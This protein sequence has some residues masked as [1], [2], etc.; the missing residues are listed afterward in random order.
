MDD[1]IR[2]EYLKKHIPYRMIFIDMLRF[3]C[4]ILKSSQH[5]AKVEILFDSKPVLAPNSVYFITNPFLEVGTLYCRVMLEF[6]GIKR[7]NKSGNLIARRACSPQ[8][9]NQDL[10]IENFGLNKISLSEAVT[11][12]FEQD[13]QK[14]EQALAST[15]MLAHRGI[16]H[17]TIDPV[18]EAT[19]ETQYLCSKVVPWLICEHLYKKMNLPRPQYEIMR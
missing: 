14:V 4:T 17:F 11:V 6:L 7:N 2:Q 18:E 3:A 19:I 5:P 8:S 16:A 12:P 10:V 13:S 1:E 9:C 15:I